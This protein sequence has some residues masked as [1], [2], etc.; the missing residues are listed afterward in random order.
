MCSPAFFINVFMVA[1]LL[2]YNFDYF[3][4]KHPETEKFSKLYEDL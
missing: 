4:K 1:T 2:L 3:K